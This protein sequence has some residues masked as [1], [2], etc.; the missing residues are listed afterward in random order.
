MIR[1]TGKLKNLKIRTQF[2]LLILTAG[3]IVFTLFNA[4]WKN[5][6]TIGQF[7]THSDLYHTQLDDPGFMTDFLES[8]K[9][10][11]IPESE[12]D[13]EQIRALNPLFDLADEYTSIYIYDGTDGYFR[14][15]R[16]AS[17]MDKKAVQRILG[18]GYN[19]TGVEGEDDRLFAVPFRNG[20][21]IVVM[22]NYKRSM[23]TQPYFIVSLFFCILLFFAIV[24]VFI[25]RK[26]RSVL[27]LEEEILNMS[28]GDLSHPVPDFGGDE[29]GILAKELDNLRVSLND[30]IVKEQESRKAN[31]DLI[32]ALSHDLRTPLTILTGYLEVLRLKRTPVTQDEYLKRCLKKTEDIKELTDRMFEYALVSE[33]NEIPEII[34]ISTDFIRQCLQE[35]SDFIKLA[36]F[37]PTL[38]MPD[39]DHVLKSDKTMLKRIFNNLFSNLLKY[40]DKKQPVDISG[41]ILRHTHTLIISVSN[42]IKQEHD[43]EGSNNIGLNNV[44]KMIKLLGGTMIIE[45]ENQIFTV[46]L[47]F[48]LS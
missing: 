8:A 28:S 40:G 44:R 30:T 48:P 14:A 20:L 35:N 34:W 22:Y 2:A 5:K 43:Q 17:V 45:K 16:Y 23:Y 18:F 9:C 42:H 10:F 19:L 11:D 36:G 3:L 37:A 24:L 21:A 27:I 38:L 1:I 39:T 25:T 33:E 46:K 47:G 7:F 12:N 4:L 15:G 41:N 32:T 13:T 31:Q 26:M 29:I 6:W